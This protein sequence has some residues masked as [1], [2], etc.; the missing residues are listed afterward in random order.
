MRRSEW[1]NMG[2]F[3]LGKA[4][5]GACVRTAGFCKGHRY[6]RTVLVMGLGVL[7]QTA[8]TAGAQQP[9][10]ENFQRFRIYALGRAQASGLR[11]VNQHI[12]TVFGL[13]GD[14]RILT[15][16]EMVLS[17]RRLT[18]T[19]SAS[20]LD[21]FFTDAHATQSGTVVTVFHSDVSLA[22]R[23]AAVG[24]RTSMLRR[25]STDNAVASHFRE[26][27]LKW[28]KDLPQMLAVEERREKLTK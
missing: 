8:V 12:V 25:M 11:P 20:S 2:A 13:T 14:I 3:A 4:L 27:L 22:L 5:L 10:V 9:S 17:G 15:D 1:H 23:A 28:D 26:V 21:V 7:L 19:F 6:M 18:L 16:G 24:E